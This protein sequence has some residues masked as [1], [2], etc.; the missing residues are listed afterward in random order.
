MGYQYSIYSIPT[1][2]TSSTRSHI[3]KVMPLP[4]RLW[5]VKETSPQIV[6]HLSY[7]T[8]CFYSHS[9]GINKGNDGKKWSWLSFFVKTMT[10]LIHQSTVQLWE[11][12]F[13]TWVKERRELNGVMTQQ[14]I[15]SLLWRAWISQ[16]FESQGF[17]LLL[18]KM[19]RNCLYHG[20]FQLLRTMLHMYHFTMYK[21]L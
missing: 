1:W 6:I 16:E 15:M 17:L 14:I 20:S 7:Q 3:L 13:H 11:V 12:R 19:T 10:W 5:L 9:N 4:T 8:A 2:T 21:A 18:W